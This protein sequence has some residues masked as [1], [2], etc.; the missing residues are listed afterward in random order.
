MWLLQDCSTCCR[1]HWSAFVMHAW[2]LE[3]QVIGECGPPAWTKE[4]QLQNEPQSRPHLQL[5]S[6]LSMT[7]TGMSAHGAGLP[8]AGHKLCSSQREVEVVQI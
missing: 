8:M 3:G 4:D 2:N 5:M 1:R 6:E 7:R